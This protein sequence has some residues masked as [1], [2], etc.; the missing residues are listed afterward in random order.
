MFKPTLEK[1]L[2]ML[3]KGLI[4]F[5]IRMGSYKSGPKM[6]KPHDHGSAFRIL[7]ANISSLYAEKEVIE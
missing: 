2:E 6:G 5:D 4:M 3:D 7:E 1:F